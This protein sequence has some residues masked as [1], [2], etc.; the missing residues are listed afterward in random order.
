MK[1]IHYLLLLA[2]TS[3]ALISPQAATVTL[4][5]SA[6]GPL[7]SSTT[8]GIIVR[9]AQAPSDAP[10]ANSFLRATRQLNGTLTDS[11]GVLIP[12]EAIAG[13]NPGGS[14][15][16]NEVNFEKDGVELFEVTDQDGIVLAE[17]LG[18]PF[19]GIPGTGGHT[20]HFAVEVVAYLELSA[21][22]HTLGVSASA[23]RTDVN[24]DDGYQ[25]FVGANPRDLFATRVA[26]YQRIAQPFVSNQHIENRWTVQA[27]VAGIYPFRIVY[28]QTKR[29]AN[30]QWYNFAGPTEVR[31]PVNDM[32]N[33]PRAI[34]AYRNTTVATANAPYVAQVSPLAGSSGIDPAEPISILL[35]D[36]S[37]ALNPNSVRLSLN[38]EQVTATV[39]REGSR[40]TIEYAPDPARSEVFNQ[41]RLDYSDSTGLAQTREWQFGITPSG[42]AVNPVTGQWD[43]E[44]GNLS[45]TVGQAL[46]YLDGAAGVTAQ[47]TTFG[48]TTALGIPDIGGQPARVMSVPGDLDKNIGYL[49][50]HGI[51]PNGGG[52]RVNQFT[53]IMDL[54][55]AETGSF[56][57]SL[58]QISSPE[59]ND[60]GDLFWQQG[61][62]GQGTDGYRG[63][64][65]FTAGAWHRVAAAYDMAANPPLVVKYVDGIK[66][67][68]WTANQGLDNPRRA[69]LPT[70][71][72]FGD[73]DQDERRAMFVNS[74]QIR[75]GRLSDAQLALLGGPT[76]E[77][78]PLVLPASNVTGQWDFE[79]G[80]LSATIGSPLQYLHERTQTNTLF[81][82][83][84][85]LGVAEIDGEPTK[86]MRVP[87]DL[88]REIGYVMEHRIAPN[89][90]GTRV[91]QYTLI[92]DVFI[93][94]TGPGAASLFQISSPENTDDGD[95]FWQGSNFGQ[96]TDGYLGRG[97]FTPGAWHRVVAAYDMAAATPVV[98]K[99][100]DG[101]KQH[102]WTANQGL[103]NPRRAL[104][105]TAVL[106]G[107]GDQD[108]RREMWVS[109]IQ[110]REGKLTDA[111]IFA[112]G[113][114]SADGIPIATPRS[115]VTGQWDF[116]FRDLGASIGSPL[117]YLHERTATNTLFGT[118]ADLGVPDIDGQIANVMYVPGDLSREIGY[119][120]EHL[121]PPNGGGTRVNQY[122]L[123]MDVLIGTTG[124]GAASMWQ[125]SSPENADDG[126]LFW[127]GGN[128]GQGS[129]GYNGTGIFTAGEWHRV[130]AAYDMAAT[131]PVVVKYVDGIFQD[132]WTANQ[133]LDNPRRALLPTAVL[134]G[135]GDED[136]RREWWVNAVQIRAGRLSNAE[137]ESLGGPSADG[138]P[139]VLTV[140]P[141]P[142]P[143]TIS[144]ALVGSSL[145]LSWPADATGYTLTS[146]PALPASSWTPVPGVT[147]NSVTL[148]TT[149]PGQYFRLQQ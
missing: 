54:F 20:D 71:V 19:P 39:T 59:N 22:E 61:N 104:L 145:T 82:T 62:F 43:F 132:N 109:S 38:G 5:A 84:T 12:N 118:T 148:N 115:T 3:A 140:Q 60:D 139:V 10:V 97:T 141:P 57:A 35:L 41:I 73:G 51:A 105:P 15:F 100:V 83:T 66:Q 2:T 8:R 64:G 46:A 142:T 74:I 81:G 144:F 69:L 117:Q 112:L 89:G 13:P 96:G 42:G 77:G 23:D 70:A 146:A 53:L 133:G 147:G 93:A 119:V 78:V 94:E 99:Y 116:T 122:T 101:I 113:G 63:K 128:F 1:R 106:F 124:P 108:E 80:D 87:G 92:M 134:F 30:L 34:K 26:E 45:A 52:T 126:D 7:G 56:A 29:A 107:D 121:I 24:D 79:F 76:A 85:D 27:P 25:V 40:T 123:V 48:T 9:S 31:L 125:V 91:N 110:I 129:E 17:F 44:S 88:S 37:T 65:T 55:V 120:M 32:F 98:T 135:D 136:E 28:W 103:D 86:V 111:Q 49:M 130:V 102:D 14:Y 50:D 149:E 90:G 33:D 127:Q 4:P 68:E 72:L 16:V 114:P 138:I 67:D 6:A 137:I 11:E 95:L 36:G 47:K 131:P 18:D 58:L 75:E 21:G 143:P